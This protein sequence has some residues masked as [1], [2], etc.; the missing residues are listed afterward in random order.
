MKA[1]QVPTRHVRTSMG[2]STPRAWYSLTIARV[3]MLP[4]TLR[5]ASATRILPLSVL[6]SPD[7]THRYRRFAA[8]LTNDNARLAEICA[9]L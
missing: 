1:S 7:R 3:S 8:I 5:K 2:S 4:S 9:G 6:N